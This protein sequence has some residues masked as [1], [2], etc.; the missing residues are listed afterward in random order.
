M[1]VGNETGRGSR[2]S[3]VSYFCKPI[4]T[5]D[6][7]IWHSTEPPAQCYSHIIRVDGQ[8][9]THMARQGPDCRYYRPKST[10]ALTSA[11]DP[12]RIS[13]LHHQTI[14]TQETSD[15]PSRGG[16]CIMHANLLALDRQLSYHWQIS[17]L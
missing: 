16:R 1:E 15:E 6:A 11:V 9:P 2:V 8:S 3:H 14:G 7:A 17:S 4:I 5:R 12:F 13:Q 10:L